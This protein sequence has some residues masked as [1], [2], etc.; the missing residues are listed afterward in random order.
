MLIPIFESVVSDSGTGE[1]AQ[2]EGLRIAGKTGTA[3][4]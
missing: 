1:F 4:K 3:K 2:V